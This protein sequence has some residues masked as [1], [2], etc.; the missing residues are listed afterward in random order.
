M[1]DEED[2]RH[3]NDRLVAALVG[4]G[5]VVGHSPVESAFRTVLRHWFLPG[6][7][8]EDV[9]SDV[10]VV[11][12]RGS[13]G[14]PVSSSSQP[15]IMAR[16]LQQ[17]R[18][19]PGQRVLEI[20]T[21]T[22][23]NAA[24]LRH[25][26]GSEGR[27][28]TV[29]LD[30]SIC[31][32]AERHLEAAG[33]ADV[34]VVAGDAWTVVQG[35]GTFDRVEATVGVSDLSPVWVEHME[36]DG[37]LVAPLWLG[38]G[39]Q[40]SV[41]FRK[42]GGGLE[43]LSA[44]PCGFMRLRGLGAG[45]PT[46]HRLGAWTVSLDRPDPARVALLRRLLALEPRVQ[47]PPALGPGWFTPIALGHPDAVHLFSL[48]AE[49]TVVCWGVLGTS[50][51]GLA[52][53][54][55]RPGDAPTLETFG[56]DQPRQRLLALMRHGDAIPVENLSISAVPAGHPVDDRKAVATLTRPNFTFVIGRNQYEPR[57]IWRH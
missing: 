20:G 34:S 52:V 41:A 23:Y 21:G 25:L 17:L 7:S 45:D 48:R 4:Q 30:A 3:R 22:G 49:G 2:A 50:P 10:A 8:L 28:T 19:E 47:P 32:A 29:D 53:V 12:H 1:P 44:D 13:D 16:M 56:A 38:A 51:P 36:A 55:S 27:V 37:I 14:V 33:A 24:L 11:T 9:Y 15:A 6:A 57:T 40:V 35:I 54:V 39:L 31:A 5:D 26:V 42:V 43:G 18:V 46:Y